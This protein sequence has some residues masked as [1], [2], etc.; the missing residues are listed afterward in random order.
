MSSVISKFITKTLCDHQGCL[1]FR[2]LDE[3]VSRSFTVAEVVM[4]SVLSD[5][6]RIAVLEG[7]Q[8]AVANKMFGPDTLVVAKTNL[9]LCQ[10]KSGECSQCDALHLCRYWVLGDCSF[11]D[12]CKN[13][14][15][16]VSLHNVDLLRRHD[17][18]ELSEKQLFQLLLQ[19][20]PWL[21]PDVCPHY[22]KGN[23][24]HGSCRYATTC[25]KLHLCL[26]FLHDD[27]KF[28]ATCKRSHNFCPADMKSLKGL[29]QENVRNLY[30]IYRNKFIITE[31]QGTRASAAAAPVVHSK[32]RSPAASVSSSPPLTDAD[33]NEICLF[34][35]RR[36]CSFKDRCARVHW[37]LPYRWQVYDDSISKWIDLQCMEDIERA[38]CDPE[39][40]SNG[41][42][43]SSPVTGI[44][45]FLNIQSNPP[46][47]EPSV[48][49]LTMTYKGSPVR[50]LSTASSASKPPHFILT[51]EWL[52]YWKENTGKWVEFGQDGSE[53]S[54][55]VSSQTLENVYL[56]DKNAQV[57]FSAGKQQY[58]ID[59]NSA[60]QQMYQQ[61]VKFK[62]KREVKRRPRFVSAPDVE[63]KLKGVT[64]QSSSSS[65]LSESVPPN[66]D[67]NAIP[68]YG[69]RLVPLTKSAKDY[70]SVE[71]LF[72]RTMPSSTITS[73]ERVQNTS[74]WKVFQ[75]QRE[76]MEKRNGGKAVNQQYLFHGTDASLVEAICEQNFDWRMCGVHGTAYGKG[77]YFARDASYSNRYSG[78]KIGTRNKIM[79][80]ALVLVGEYTKGTAAYVRPP[81]KSD[82]KTFYD[83]C[84][85][86]T[87]DPS[88]FV[89][90][91][92]QQIYPEYV[93]KYV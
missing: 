30:R 33:K 63:E 26:R 11:R 20:D 70:G 85:N 5:E 41:S 52:W 49:F 45:R 66:W 86:Q 65:A 59:F 35:I 67:K 60:G 21:L 64:S 19:N 17:L 13:D 14:H 46:A 23:G 72:K 48:D 61:N 93:I 55:S 3:T 15:S 54:A 56:A 69:Y 2:R 43:A 8:K 42:Q 22:N 88:I 24:P 27:C 73:L 47:D 50:R 68:D 76:Q 80:V 18:Q 78:V 40:D 91:E 53:T 25:T 75:W 10:K 71:M 39:R 6:S 92:K 29:S 36:N 4:Q 87:S 82:G 38:Y 31:H 79:F 90:F 74:L 77:S 58:V 81:H 57:P 89:I 7:K 84:V 16:L 1:D 12:R 32:S 9:R 37:H 62:T 28:G 34:F 51:T 83:S 44:F